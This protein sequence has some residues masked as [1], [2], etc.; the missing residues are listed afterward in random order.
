MA[1]TSRLLIMFDYL[2]ERRAG[3][4]PPGPTTDQINGTVVEAATYLSVYVY[5]GATSFFIYQ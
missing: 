2:R 4:W 3:V 5:I 1:D